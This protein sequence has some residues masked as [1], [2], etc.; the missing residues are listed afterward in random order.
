MTSVEKFMERSR[1]SGLSYAS[2]AITSLQDGSAT[3]I[4]DAESVVPV[5]ASEL[6]RIYERRAV[7]LAKISTDHAKIMA[8]DTRFLCDSLRAFGGFHCG[9]W[10]VE[11]V[12][13]F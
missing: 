13:F 11:R 6:L 1:S 4:A 2:E 7:H 8:V 12:L 10:M 9:I 5:S 3:L